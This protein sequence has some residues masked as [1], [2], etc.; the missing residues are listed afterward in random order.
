MNELVKACGPFIYP[1]VLL[2][3]GGL[4]IIIERLVALRSGRIIPIRLQNEIIEKDTLPP[5]EARSSV[6][7][8]LLFH[9]QRHPDAEQIKAFANMEA[10]S[11]ERG[12]FILEIVIAVAPLIGLL[13]TAIGL[14]Q[15]FSHVDAR[16]GGVEDTSAFASGVALPLATTVVGLAIA[17]PAV[18][19]NAYLN[20]RID[21]LAARLNVLVERIISIDER[22]KGTSHESV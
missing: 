13:G 10:V 14:V 21:T 11:M 3:F 20:R 2:S 9:E 17:I 22:N 7:R 4:F 18:V 8:I 12:M 19:F 16:S 1:L 6:G 5:G 15:V